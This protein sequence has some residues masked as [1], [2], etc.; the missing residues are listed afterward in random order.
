MLMRV[1]IIFIPG[2]NR[3]KLRNIAV[4]LA[5]GIESNGHQVDI[6]DGK[7]DVNVKLTAHQYIGMGTEASSMF[8]GK[9]S[10]K[11]APFLGSAGHLQG[12]R[13]FAFILKSSFGSQKAL[14]RLMQAMEKEGMFLKYSDVIQS[15]LEAN[16][17]G[18][19]LHIQ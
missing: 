12:K 5:K 1:A 15:E 7:V 11:I 3:E 4:A 17:I 16:E 19:R 8:G 18:K 10:E 9:I 13:C 2:K 6:I 14:T